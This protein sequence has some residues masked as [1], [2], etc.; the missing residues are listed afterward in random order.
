MSLL[1]KRRVANKYKRRHGSVVQSNHQSPKIFYNPYT[2][3][4]QLSKAKAKV[5]KTPQFKIRKKEI[6]MGEWHGD[7]MSERPAAHETRFV[8]QNCN[9]LSTSNDLNLF[10]SQMTDLITK[11]I[12]F[13]ALPEINVNCVNVNLTNGYRDA[14]AEITNNGIFSVT[15]SAVFESNT[16]YQPG[17]V[18]S[19][20]FGK[21]VTRYTSN[22]KDKYG[23]W[24]YQEFQGKKT[25]LRIYTVY[26]TNYA[27]DNTAGQITSWTQERLLLLQ[28]GIEDNPRHRVIH[29]LVNE[30]QEAI[31]EGNSIIVLA[32]LNEHIHG[33]EKTH[34]KLN[35]IG[36]INVF[37]DRLGN[38]LPRTHKR[39]KEAIDHIFVTPNV[40]QHIT[41]AG[42]A[43][44]DFG[45]QSDHR[46]LMFDLDLGGL[47]DPSVNMITPYHCRRLKTTVPKRMEKYLEMLNEL[48]DFHK[49]D[50]RIIR[51][52]NKFRNGD[53]DAEKAINDLDEM[54]TGLMRHSEKKCSKAGKHHTLPWSP[55]LHYGILNIRNCVYALKESL[56]LDPERTLSEQLEIYQQAEKELQQARVD[57]QEIKKEA[58]KKR[59]TFLD[60]RVK[61]YQTKLDIAPKS[62]LKSLK[63]IET[64]QKNSVKIGFALQKNNRKGITH[65][66]IPAKEEYPEELRSRYREIPIMWR[67]IEKNNGK[68]IRHWEQ[69]SDREKM[70]E[71]L[72]L[73][74]RQHFTQASETPLSTREWRTKLMD[75]ITQEN[76]LN[77]EMSTYGDI[78]EE[79]KQIFEYMQTSS[80][81]RNK[82][83][84]KTT[85]EEFRAFVKTAKE[86]SSCSPSGRNYSHYK[87]LVDDEKILRALHT[88]FEIALD[89][90]IVLNRWAK[91][92][93]T[94]IPKDQGPILVHRLRAIHV[95]EAELQFFSKIVYAKKMVN[96]AEKNTL[97]T[98]E[99]YGGRKGRRAQSIVLNKLLYYS[100]S[101]QKREN[102]A[103]MDDDAKACYDR[104]IPS[105][106]SVEVQKWGVSKKAA[107]LTQKI[108]ESQKFNVKTAQGIS[109]A[110]YTFDANNPTFGMGQG[111]GWSGAVWMVSSDTICKILEHECAGMMFI[112]P[113]KKIIVTK[114]GDL[115]VDDTALGV[116]ANRIKNGNTVLQQLEQDEQKHALLLF[117]EGHRLALQKC[118]YYISTYI[119]EGTKHRHKLIHEEP[120][121]LRLREGYGLELKTVKR[122]QPFEA[123]RTLGNFISINGRQTCQ[124]RHLKKLVRTWVNRVKSSALSKQN[125]LL[126]Y[127]GYLIPSLSYRLA[128]SS[129][130]F[131]QCKKLQTLLDPILLHAHGLQR[132]TPKIVLFSTST[133]AGLNISH[134]YHVQGQEKLKLL[135]MHI[136]RNDTTG[137]LLNIS[138]A[139]TQIELGIEKSFLT[140]NFHQYSAYITPTWTT[141]LWN[142]LT[143]C[144]A[145]LDR[146]EERQWYEAPR[147]NDFFIMDLVFQADISQRSKEIFNQIRTHLKLLTASDMV[148][149]GS[150]YSLLPCL[151]KM[152]NTRESKWEWPVVLPFPS[153]WKEEWDSILKNIIQPRIR[154]KPLG[155]WIGESHQTWT[156]KISQNGLKLQV[157][158]EF[159]EFSEGVR[160]RRFIPT[161][162]PGICTL[163]ADVEYHDGQV[164]V[165][166]T[167]EGYEDLDNH[168]E[169][170]NNVPL[171]M[172][173]NWGVVATETQLKRVA[174]CIAND[175]LMAAGD[176]S[177]RHQRSGQ[178]WTLVDVMSEEKIITGVAKVNGIGSEQSSTRAELFGIMASV[179]L[180]EYVTK[181]YNLSSGSVDIYTDSKVS[182][183]KISTK[184]QVSTK[185]VCKLDNDIAFEVQSRIKKSP[186]RIKVLY[187]KGHQDEQDDYETLPLE[188]RLN[189][190]MDHKIGEYLD[191]HP[192]QNIKYPKLPA[193]QYIVSIRGELTPN[194]IHTKLIASYNDEAWKTHV[195]KRLGI[196]PQ[197]IKKA[198]WMPIGKLLSNS[199]TRGTY[200]KNLHHELNLMPR[201]KQWKTATS[202]KCPLCKKKNETWDHVLRCK[203]EHSIRTRKESIDQ[204]RTCLIKLNTHPAITN[205]FLSILERWILKKAPKYTS[206]NNPDSI[207]LGLGAV[208]ESQQKIGWNAFVQ[209]IISQEWGQL[210]QQ[211][212]QEQKLGDKYN[213]QRWRNKI[214]QTLF[215]W[216]RKM[217]KN[218]CEIVQ[219]KDQD[220]LEQRKRMQ[221]QNLHQRLQKKPWKLKHTSRHL[222]D[223]N[224]IFFQK[225]NIIALDVWEQLI[226]VAME[227]ANQESRTNDIRQYGTLSKSSGPVQKVLTLRPTQITR[228]Y[229]QLTFKRQQKQAK[230]IQGKRI[231]ECKELQKTQTVIEE[232]L[233]S[234]QSRKQKQYVPYDRGKVCKQSRVLDFFEYSKY[235]PGHRLMARSSHDGTTRKINILNLI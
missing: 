226:F 209:G 94:L 57:Y 219:I 233:N 190:D 50:D 144:H 74:Q 137:K 25:N 35:N 184:R 119:R 231:I 114:R 166:S 161:K 152:E 7:N 38:H 79:C 154:H 235:N 12:H 217:W 112:S 142:Y 121:E 71:I 135:L 172:Q 106:A 204:V 216:N 55:E 1:R 140:K 70:E 44:F 222:L 165:I 129:L 223:R 218:R 177:V 139:Q 107:D 69:I 214:V 133:Q 75:E 101:L 41:R 159:F 115:F 138:I 98:D 125:R 6:T 108:V 134:L 228:K 61:Y 54:I 99:Q 168:N 120:G 179:S 124:F 45:L 97:I 117:A 46:P 82:V 93:T 63:H 221:L 103:F 104:I 189:C 89:N 19:G 9:G 234:A 195:T 180:V 67:K 83:T 127:H 95:V 80:Q 85:Y 10:K 128:T 196:P 21:L 207:E 81:I 105:L 197:M 84:H 47:L 146:T 187:V 213:G 51:V 130:T 28:D 229:T 53:E 88:I 102:A 27:T 32:D 191:H 77:G 182:I 225:A 65:I 31:N 203:N 8:L 171:W 153:K 181:K 96:F 155:P 170:Q 52:A 22:K 175:T 91:T 26:R 192:T 110:N 36:L 148:E 151:F 194:F 167:S 232:I 42:I 123:H 37:Q 2:K 90:D 206:I 157:N 208:F 188:A 200:V 199:G 185:D 59:D 149:V 66:L 11:D 109:S 86:K 160:R 143:D 39:G 227:Q 43:P 24:H 60:D 30:L 72:V 3:K 15:N 4:L 18:G 5:V 17:G 230:A 211:Y 20:F 201:C 126:A 58:D 183:S 62:I 111:L 158:G 186:I 212:V 116:T 174:E 49:I 48:W 118:C 34:E 164:Y 145:T 33:S 169:I 78:P 150:S 14:F 122:L 76:I 40:I 178:A 173:A 56:Y 210:Q 176:G 162:Y 92:V 220:T 202:G 136:R 132:N 131:K 163:R 23:R 100:I 141:H 68:D 13:L 193:Q 113:D 147:V 224:D 16:K 73:W 29:D 198:D 215:E 64:Q 156:T 205:L 87:T